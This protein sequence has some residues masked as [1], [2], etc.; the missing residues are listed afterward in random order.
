MSEIQARIDNKIANFTDAVVRSNLD[1]AYDAMWDIIEDVI[2]SAAL[3]VRNHRGV[4]TAE[5]GWDADDIADDVVNT[6]NDYV[7]NH[8]GQ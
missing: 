3:A 5:S 1:L 6:V 8:Y 4:G 7:T 2:D